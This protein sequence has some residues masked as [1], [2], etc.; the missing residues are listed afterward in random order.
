MLHANEKP[1]DLST[2]IPFE[3]SENLTKDEDLDSVI[4]IASKKKLE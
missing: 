2:S 1:I 4:Y 3:N